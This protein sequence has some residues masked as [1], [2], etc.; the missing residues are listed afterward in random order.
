MIDYIVIGGGSA[1]CVLAARLSEDPQ[2]Q[3]CLLE[4]GASDNNPLIQCPAGLAALIPYPIFNWAFKTIPNRGMNGRIGYQPRGKALGGSS[5]INGMMYIRG[6]RTDYDQW[7]EAGNVGWSYAEVLPYFRKSEN[8]AFWG[9]NAYHGA[10]GPLNVADVL[11]P[12]VYARAFVEAG[13][14]AGHLPNPDFNGDHQLGVGLTQVTQKNG[15]RCSTAKAFLTPNLGR[16]NL[17]VITGAQAT[18]IVMEGKRAVGVEYRQGSAIK[19][20]KA[21]QEVLL[22]A[23]ALQSPQ[24]LMLSGIGPAANLQQH[25][26]D[27]VHDSPGVGQ[28]LQDHIDIVHSYEAGA[29]RGLFGLSLSGVWSVAKGIRTWAKYRRGVL[30]SNFAEGTGFVK[31]RPEEARPDV[32]LVFI[33]AK[34]MDHG[35]KILLG[36]GYSV[37]CGLLRPKS[38]GSVSLASADPLAPPLIDTNFLSDQDDVSRLISALKLTRVVM[39]QPALARFGGKESRN[40]ARAQT[41]AQIEAFIRNHADCAY[42]PVGTCRMGNGALDVVDDRLRVKGVQGLRVVDASIMPNIVSGN[43][44]APTVMIAE[45]AADM[46]KAAASAATRE[47]TCCAS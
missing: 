34:L 27:V 10:G 30:T 11:E 43:T 4:A 5:S 31:T 19:V 25:G 20:L 47:G 46:I 44:N 14:Q 42:H 33:V 3:V 16:P 12:S 29:S 45:K 9:S 6:D 39:R 15:E 21:T 36:N 38:R 18:R 8:N 40:S 7:A 37:H 24:I 1:G 32:Q 2:V 13:L 28:N 26:I 23:G 17:K 41:D 35:R 22:S